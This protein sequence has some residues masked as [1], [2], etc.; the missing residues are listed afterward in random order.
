MPSTNKEFPSLKKV[1][2]EQ[3]KK[4]KLER[5]EPVADTIATV[6]AGYIEMQAGSLGPLFPAIPHD[7]LGEKMV[8]LYRGGE[9][10]SPPI[11]K[12]QRPIFRGAVDGVL[13][14]MNFSWPEQIVRETLTSIAL[15]AW[16]ENDLKALK[17]AIAAYV[18]SLYARGLD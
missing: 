18:V 15:G 5:P 8:G 6:A 10:P 13:N 17:G 4:K 3:L 11:K 2:K 12:M 7:M 1:D 14:S 9:K 16:D